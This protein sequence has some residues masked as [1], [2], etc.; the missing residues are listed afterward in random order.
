VK[1]RICGLDCGV[2]VGSGTVTHLGP[3]RYTYCGDVFIVPVII[4]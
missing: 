4:L 3:A 2:Y 1:F